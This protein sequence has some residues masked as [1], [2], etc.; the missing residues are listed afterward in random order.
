M[1]DAWEDT[2]AEPDTKLAT[3]PMWKS[4][5]IWV[6]NAPDPGLMF[7]KQ[8]QHQNPVAGQINYIY[9]KIHNSGGATNRTLQL[10]AGN[11]SPACHGKAVLL[12][13]ERS[14]CRCSH[15]TQPELQ[16]YRGTRRNPVTTSYLARWE[17]ASDGMTETA[18]IDRN[19][20]NNNN[21]VVR[22]NVNIVTLGP[23]V[24]LD[25]NLDRNLE[26]AQANLSD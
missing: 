21:I 24:T 7:E 11:A 20:R 18:D 1:K 8:H 22:R 25:N 5:Y 19:V 9:V 15:P 23:P 6:R 13:W 14:L 4:P 2:G 16:K 26:G 17:S 10:W 3:E 12:N